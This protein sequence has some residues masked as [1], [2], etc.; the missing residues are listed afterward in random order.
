[1]GV[2]EKDEEEKRKKKALTNRDRDAAHDDACGVIGGGSGGI[3]GPV[4]DEV[5]DGQVLSV[6]E[7]DGGHYGG[8]DGRELHF[9]SE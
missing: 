8:R 1:M 2:V 3:R 4:Q 9:F 7:G 5:F 6:G